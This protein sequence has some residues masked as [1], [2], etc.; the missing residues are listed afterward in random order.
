MADHSPNI[1]R[2]MQAIEKKF[3]SPY[4]EAAAQSP[5]LVKPDGSPLISPEPS[6]YSRIGSKKSG[7]MKKWNPVSING[8]LQDMERETIVDRAGDLVMNDPNA[9]GVVET[10]AN[11]VVGTGLNPHPNFDPKMVGMT[12][13]EGNEFKDK[14]RDVVKVWSPF[15]D[16][17]GRM[18]FGGCQFLAQR[19]VVQHGE[20]LFLVVM[21]SSPSRPYYLCL[22]S[23]SPKRLKTPID[24]TKQ[25]NLHNGVEVGPR[26]EPRA[27]WIKKTQG[28]SLM[29]LSDS[30]ENFVRISARKGHRVKVLHGFMMNESEQ[31]RGMPMFGPG[32]KFFRDLSDYLDAELVANVIT[33]AFALFIETGSVNPLTQAERTATITETGYK[34]DGTEYDQRYEEIEPGVVMYGNAG[35]K[36]YSISA[37]R[38]GRTFDVFIKRILMSIANSTGVPYPVLFQDFEGMN[39]ASYRS[40]ML[41]AWR[42][43]RNRR[44]WLGE[45]FCQPL[46][47]MLIEEAWLRDEIQS[48]NFYRDMNRLTSSDW[49]GPPKG[50]IEPIKE[51]QADILAVNNN[52]KTLEEVLLENDRELNST[53]KQI[54]AEKDLQEEMG[55]MPVEESSGDQDGQDSQKNE[56]DVNS[57]AWQYISSGESKDGNY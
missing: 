1:S 51:V 44:R 16:V 28:S 22:Q 3:Q 37:D 42:V 34:S 47:R 15:A 32:M 46:Y 49:I 30:S 13:D 36:P 27:Y 23:I 53:L 31:F 33:A 35:E 8:Q 55:I 9:A 10:F 7:S 14:C 50:Q 25:T 52:F 29:R 57:N 18:T 56:P 38:P 26:G 45:S 43:F 41:E 11:T 40:A 6:T 5:G 39:Y 2:V 20:Y 19:Q 54:E 17:A 48:D 12:D 21:D 24:L 4:P